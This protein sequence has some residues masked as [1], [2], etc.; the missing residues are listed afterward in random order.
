MVLLPRF[1][2]VPSGVSLDRPRPACK[3]LTRL[4]RTQ[5]GFSPSHRDEWLSPHFSIDTVVVSMTLRHRL[6]L[7]YLIVVLLSAAT[8][9]AAVFEL[10]HARSTLNDLLAWNRLRLEVEK[11]KWTWPPPADM[12]LDNYDMRDRLARLFLLVAPP[13]EEETDE[14][15]AVHELA[16]DLADAVRKLLN[17]LYRGY[18]EWSSLSA[19]HRAAQFHL[20]N[21]PL[22]RL[23]LSLDYELSNVEAQASIQEIRTR[24]L[25]V[26]V[27]FVILLHIVTIGSLLRRWLL[28]PMQQLNRQV[29]SLARDEPP[30]EPLLTSPREVAV[31]AAA[32]E[33]ARESLG[34]YRQQLITSE[35][36][37]TIGQMAAQLAHNLRNP[38]ASIRAAAQ[39]TLQTHADS[40]ALN[41]RMADIMVSVDRLNRW[42]MGLME[43]ARRDPTLTRHMDVVPTVQRAAESVCEEVSVKE[44]H[45][46]VN[47]PVEGLVCEHDANTLEHALFAMLVNAVEASPMGA[48]LEVNVSRVARAEG[49]ACR[50]SVSDHGTGLPADNPERIFEFS[51]S[52]K[53]QGMGLGLALARQGLQRQGGSIHACN[54]PDGGATV[55]VELPIAPDIADEPAA[56]QVMEESSVV[57]SVDSREPN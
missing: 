49:Q 56:G 26:I 23:E 11:L 24:V 42:V 8:V 1:V 57:S 30:A 20:V 13:S 3:T 10:H 53:Q 18:N 22:R 50:I 29:E 7:V 37:T 32:L 27:G 35:R 9:G 43:V 19:E 5:D 47:A 4:G 48:D 54:N 51:Y 15:L 46:I 34:S 52:T 14:P 38:L 55:Y 45:L 33:R 25:L 16:P 21:N 44:L 39:V 36:L 31:L 41:Q 12:P 17:E 40:P 28:W 6:L 2:Q